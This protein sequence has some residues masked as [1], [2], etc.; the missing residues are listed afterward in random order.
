MTKAKIKAMILE[1]IEHLD[2][3]SYKNFLPDCS[4]DFES[5]SELMEELIEVAQ[6]HL[7]KSK[8]K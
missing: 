2:Y 4:E 6:K 3:D 8:K 1:I 5:A 7:P